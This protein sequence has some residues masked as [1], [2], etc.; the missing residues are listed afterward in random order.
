M[1]IDN[2]AISLPSY[3]KAVS[4]LLSLASPIFKEAMSKALETPEGIQDKSFEHWYVLRRVAQ[5]WLANRSTFL[6]TA[7]RE[8]L[9]G[10]LRFCHEQA[11]ALPASFGNQVVPRVEHCACETAR[12]LMDLALLQVA[13]A[14]GV[15]ISI[16]G[17][18]A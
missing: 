3:S 17:V 15:E 4:V 18:A 5:C 6:C 9:I 14:T 1:T 16:G 2:A 8:A 10:A 13:D 12:K 11:H 7:E